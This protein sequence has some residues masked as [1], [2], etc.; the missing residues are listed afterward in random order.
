[1]PDFRSHYLPL[2][3]KG[4]RPDGSARNPGPRQTAVREIT[5]K[6]RESPKYSFSSSKGTAAAEYKMPW[7]DLSNLQAANLQIFQAKR[8]FLGYSEPV[9]NNG[10][11]GKVVGISRIIPYPHPQDPNYLYADAISNIQGDVPLGI[12][13]N[14]LAQYDE[15]SMSVT[16]SSREYTIV[17][18]GI[19]DEFK[20]QQY[21]TIKV[22]PTGR[23]ERIPNPSAMRFYNPQAQLVPGGTG[24]L[25]VMPGGNFTGPVVSN[26]AVFTIAEG[27]V[28]ITWH[29]IPVEAIPWTAISTCVGC[30]DSDRDPNTALFNF[31]ADTYLGPILQPSTG[32]NKPVFLCLVP[33]ISDPYPMVNG[34]FAV[35]IQYR[36][37]YYPFGVNYFYNWNIAQFTLAGNTTTG[38]LLYQAA[39]FNTL[40]WGT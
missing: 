14:N 3:I 19:F 4:Q 17:D 15:A 11:N 25:S 2:T 20:L 27:E 40:F 28:F 33:K 5:V 13:S 21:V 6:G 37:K 24:V 39:H 34:R 38:R 12:D 9:Y 35:D 29:Q 31:L 18:S 36:F 26:A 23:Y 8:D 7:A 16:F 32:R 1:M 22:E 10:N 30:C